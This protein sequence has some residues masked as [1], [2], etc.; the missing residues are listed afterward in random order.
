MAQSGPNPLSLIPAL[1]ETGTEH[2]LGLEAPLC[3][4]FVP[5]IARLDYQTYPR[6]TAFAETGRSP[7]ERKVSGTLPRAWTRFSSGWIQWARDRHPRT[8]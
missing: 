1:D 5:N 6:L 3:T 4:D 7:K 2:I 8:T